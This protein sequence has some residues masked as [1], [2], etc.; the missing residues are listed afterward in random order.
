MLYKLHKFTFYLVLRLIS[1]LHNAFILV[2]SPSHHTVSYSIINKNAMV[3]SELPKNPNILIKTHT[4]KATDKHLILK[5]QNYY[6]SKDNFKYCDF[7]LNKNHVKFT[8]NSTVG[9][10][11]KQLFASFLQKSQ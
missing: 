4:K 1:N 8:F 5:K 2:H 11:N 6:R 7:K 9:T 3:N 10:I